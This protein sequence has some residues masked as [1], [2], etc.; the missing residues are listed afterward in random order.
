M[1]RKKK[2]LIRKTQLFQ[3][4]LESIPIGTKVVLHNWGPPQNYI[5]LGLKVDQRGITMVQL[6]GNGLKKTYKVG[7]LLDKAIG[8][9]KKSIAIKSL[10]QVGAI[11]N[12]QSNWDNSVW[13][14][15][16]AAYTHRL[17]NEKKT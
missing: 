1:T 17:E 15:S 3:A 12:M 16:L 9:Q 8:V 4:N 13:L 10:T 5:F 14:E 2:Q 6:Q 11:P 7:G